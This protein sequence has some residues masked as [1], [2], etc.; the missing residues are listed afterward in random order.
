MKIIVAALLCFSC[1]SFSHAQ[2]KVK[3][4]CDPFYVDVL[5]GTINKVKANFTSGEIKEKFPCFTTAEEEGQSAKC[6]EKRS[7]RNPIFFY[8]WQ[9]IP[10]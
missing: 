3:A 6:G 9:E 2:L 4:K 8:Q 1:I 5:N 10:G 7:E